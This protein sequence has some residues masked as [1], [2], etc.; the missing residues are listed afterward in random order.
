VID[1]VAIARAAIREGLDT[2][3]V[4]QLA[5]PELDIRL[6]SITASGSSHSAPGWSTICAGICTTCGR[7]SRS[8]PGC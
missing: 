6:L 2:L 3:P 5:G 8:P 7:S 1:A 4:A